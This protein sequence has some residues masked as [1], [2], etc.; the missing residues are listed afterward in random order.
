[1]MFP[2]TNPVL[3]FLV[4]LVIILVVPILLNKIKIPHILG[5]IIAGAIIGPHGFNLLLR[6]SSII[7]SGTAGLLYI[8]FLAGLDID[9]SEFRKNSWKSMVFGLY[10]FIVPMLLGTAS[11]LYILKFSLPASILLASMFASHTLISY[12][13]LSKLG[14]T[15]NRAVN[16]SIGG[17]IITDTLALLILAVIVGMSKGDVSQ[18]FWIRLSISLSVFIMIILVFYPLIARWFF[19]NFKDSVSQYIFVLVMVFLG[20]ALAQAAGIEAIIGAFFSGLALNRLIPRSSALKNRIDFVGNAIFIPFFLIG[21]GMLVNYRVFF[22]DIST[23]LVAAVMT[24]TATS[25]KFI[26]AWLTQ[27]TFRL[28]IDERRLIFGLS[29]AQAA[30]TLAAVIVGYNVII[31]V[32]PGGE[33]VRLLSESVLNGTIIMIL[34]TCTIATFSAQK[35]GQNLALTETTSFGTDNSLSTE[36]ILIPVSNPDNIDELLNLGFL[37]RTGSNRSEFYALNIVSNKLP[38]SSAGEQGE[39]LLEKAR[40]FAASADIHLHKILRYDINVK[41]GIASVIREQNITDMILGL[42][43]KKDVSDPFLGEL[44]EGILARSNPT[45]YIYRPT[46]PISTI[47]R[48]IVVIPV[49]AEHEKGFPFWLKKIWS[50][51][52]NTGIKVVFHAPEK[53]I[54]IIKHIQE[55]HHIEADFHVFEEWDDFLIL[56]RDIKNDDNLIIVMSRPGKM[57]YNESMSRIPVYLNRYFGS[58]SF[59]LLYPKQSGISEQDQI[60][61]NNPSL[62]EPIEKVDEL[63]RTIVSIFRKK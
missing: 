35:G 37:I 4:I 41:N 27:K 52:R 50:I 57:S 33:P 44:T 22:T 31:G 20:A 23:L 15:K 24:V 39:E 7:L 2:I 14:V 21:V 47:R 26:A 56:A 10:T 36:K 51:A 30:A 16:I 46:Q 61:Y 28:T 11:G 29:N 43:S 58:N 1:M 63:S 53:T 3:Q 5:L 55:R 12:P 38:E 8:M 25:A 40:V 42:H 45:T 17:T 13:I 59:I 32:T 6:D 60:D 19:K 9:F 49:N 18:S 34:I 54:R 62:R 48:H